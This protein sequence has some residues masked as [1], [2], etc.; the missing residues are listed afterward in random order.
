MNKPAFWLPVLLIALALALLWLARRRRK[1]TGLPEGQIHYAD[2]GEWQPTS[3]PL[4]DPRLK[5]AGKPDYLVHQDGLLIPVEVKTGRTPQRPY[6]S[7]IMQLAA[8][9]YLV[10]VST[11]KT[12]PKGILC[13][14][15]RTFDI[16]YT[17]ALR[18]SLEAQIGAMRTAVQ[19]GEVPRSH[20]STARCA[21]CSYRK[22]CDQRLD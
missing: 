21:G 8:Y 18:T 6:E 15:E 9:C 4:Y 5:L 20:N 14:P 10:E 12:P 1:Q 11:G 17:P 7:H 2:M 16:A 3:Q 13:Y 19:A 22:V